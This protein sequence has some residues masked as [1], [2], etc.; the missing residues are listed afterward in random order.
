MSRQAQCSQGKQT[1]SAR[2]FCLTVFEARGVSGYPYRWWRRK[3]V[4]FGGDGRCKFQ[5]QLKMA[6]GEGFGGGLDNGIGDES[7]ATPTCQRP[8][9]ETLSS[10]PH[11]L[12][13]TPSRDLGKA[14]VKEVLSGAAGRSGEVGGP[15]RRSSYAAAKKLGFCRRKASICA[16]RVEFG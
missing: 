8:G 6:F 16:F 5:W 2:S 13:S 11:L 3:G 9:V 4:N 10:R 7:C 14:K 12:G 15:V 1:L